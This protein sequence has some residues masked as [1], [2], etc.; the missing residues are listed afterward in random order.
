MVEK[1]VIIAH[2][3]KPLEWTRLV[4]G[5]EV[6]IYTSNDQAPYMQVKNRGADSSHY[7]SFII[8][9]YENLPERM[10]FCHDHNINWTQEHPLH[11]IINNL[12]WEVGKYFSIG[13]RCNYW[14]AIPYDEKPHH[15]EAMKR[16]WYIL[17][18][19]IEYPERLTYIAGTQFC[20]HRDLIL[21]YPKEFYENCRRWVYTVE[22]AE[23]FI[24]RF[25]EYTWHYILTRN[26]IEKD[27]K[28]MI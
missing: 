25:F 1:A 13:A 20:V 6:I 18:P 15:I 14:A 21:S 8:D 23:W 26:P 10:V 27:L 5:V 7:L 24:G 4:R 19:Y 9:N 2:Y 16:N 11:H 28:Y 12:N 22:E 17:A 3:N